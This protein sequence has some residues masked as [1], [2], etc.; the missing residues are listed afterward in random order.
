MN[1]NEERNSKISQGVSAPKCSEGRKKIQAD[2]YPRTAVEDAARSFQ[3]KGRKK[4]HGHSAHPLY[5]AWKA[6]IDRCYKPTMHAYSRYG[7]RG[8]LVCRRWHEI[9]NFIGDMGECPQGMSLDRRD[10]DSGYSPENCRWATGTEQQL[11]RRCKRMVTAF[12]VTRHIFE[13]ADITGI[14]PATIWLRIHKQKRTP[15]I[16]VSAP[17]QKGP[18]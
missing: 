3:Q 1:A 10:N 13:W 7:G 5:G 18:W 6:M 9:S 15:E 12:G 16:A 11:N 2:N 14:R 4:A 8:I 17:S